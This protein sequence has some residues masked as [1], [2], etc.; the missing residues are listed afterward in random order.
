VEDARPGCGAT[1]ACGLLAA[2]R[3]RTVV[4][5]EHGV[6]RRLDEEE[7][8]E[9]LEPVGLLGREVARLRPVAVGVVQLPDVV[10]ERGDRV[11]RSQ[12][13]VR[14]GVHAAQPSW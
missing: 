8:L 1:L 4:E 2:H 12:E 13:A 10:A 7:L 14:C 6:P 3:E 11:S 5:R 9:A